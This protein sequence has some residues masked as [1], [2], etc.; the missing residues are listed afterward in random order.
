[1]LLMARITF[2]ADLESRRRFW[3]AFWSIAMIAGAAVLIIGLGVVIG[4]DWDNI[5]GSGR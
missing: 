2:D 5:F 3:A 1:M 4:L